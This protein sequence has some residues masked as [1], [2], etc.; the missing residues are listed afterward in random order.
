[1]VVLSRGV[2]CLEMSYII[3]VQILSSENGEGRNVSRP[4]LDQGHSLY[5]PWSERLKRKKKRRPPTCLAC[6]IQIQ[7]IEK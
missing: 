5:R 7:K 1:M 6:Q 4:P 3:D 2:S